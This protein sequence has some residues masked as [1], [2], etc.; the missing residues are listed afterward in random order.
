[1]KIGNN[2]YTPPFWWDSTDEGWFIADSFGK[3]EEDD[4]EGD[5]VEMDDILSAL[6]ELASLRQERDDLQKRVEELG[7]AVDI[8]VIE[9]H[10]KQNAEL[11]NEFYEVVDDLRNAGSIVDVWLLDIGAVLKKHGYT[12]KIYRNTNSRS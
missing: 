7:E 9:F 2:D 8:G 4:C 12:L 1:M 6:N 11:R 10:T 5:Q 3:K